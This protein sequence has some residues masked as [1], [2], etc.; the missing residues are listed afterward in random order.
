MA[1]IE[2]L[3]NI[4]NAIRGKTGGTDPLTLDGMVEA[5]A[6]IETG[7]G[8]SDGGASGIY[9]A[10]ITPASDMDELRITHN[11]G[12]TDI[13]VAVC[14]AETLGDVT[15]A[16]DGAV[17]NVYLKS[18]LP[19]RLTNSINHENM[20]AFARWSVSNA[21]VNT[22]APPSSDAYYSEAVNE[23]TFVFDKAGAS[24]A[25]WM[26]GVTYTVIIMTASAFSVSEV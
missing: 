10:K 18:S 16:F 15:P 23:N 9:M 26:A 25:K 17:A 1:L 7:G 13:L 3:T 12:T 11:L 19:F 8:G 21:N 22:V 5:I 6:G 2:K 24:P 4:A 14:W 20:I